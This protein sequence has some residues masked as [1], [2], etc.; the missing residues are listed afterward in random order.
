MTTNEITKLI[1]AMIIAGTG[2][3]RVWAD[4]GAAMVPPQRV[5]RSAEPVEQ[6]RSTDLVDNLFL[7]TGF[8]IEKPPGEDS[9]WFGVLGANWGIPLSPPDGVAWGLQLGAS[10][11]VRDDDPEFNLTFGGFARNFAVMQE[12][13]GA[14]A[15]LF[16][17]RHT[18]ADNDVWAFRPILGTTLD[19]DNSVG[20]E[21][22]AGLNRDHRQEVID[23]F[24]AFWTR[25]WGE[26]LVTELGIGYQFSHVDEALFRGRVALALRRFTDLSF[27]LDANTDGDYALGLGLSYNFGGTSRHATVRNIGGSGRELFAPFPAADFPVL[28]HRSGR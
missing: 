24:S 23:E 10:L 21:I 6:A 14:F 26:D 19:P 18:S 20:V 25:D 22:V 9:T 28:M 4:Q 17:Y 16:D 3:V 11:K 2:V 12:Q 1:L 13:Q 5:Y 7:N 27:G 15:V 8:G